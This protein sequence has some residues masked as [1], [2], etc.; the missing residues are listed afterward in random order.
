MRKKLIVVSLC[1]VLIFVSGCL[2]FNNIKIG[3]EGGKLILGGEIGLDVTALTS[4]LPSKDTLPLAPEFTPA[5]DTLPM[6]VPKSE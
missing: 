4:L 5:T 6:T 3:A 1:S 2:L